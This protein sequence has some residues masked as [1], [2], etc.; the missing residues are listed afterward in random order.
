MSQL[1]TRIDQNKPLRF[2]PLA[3]E[4]LE[5][6]VHNIS[7]VYL[8]EGDD[9]RTVR[10][11]TTEPCKGGFL[12]PLCPMQ[13]PLINMIPQKMRYDARGNE[14]HFPRSR[15]YGVLGY[16]HNAGEPRILVAS[17]T[18][19]RGM[20]DLLEEHEDITNYTFKIKFE[21]PAYSS[22]ALARADDDIQLD[23]VDLTQ[24]TDRMRQQF[25]KDYRTPRSSSDLAMAIDPTTTKS[26]RG[27]MTPPPPREAEPVATQPP[28]RKAEAP[29]PTEP[30]E[31][32]EKSTEGV[33]VEGIKR[34]IIMLATQNSDKFTQM[35]EALQELGLDGLNDIPDDTAQ[36][37][38]AAV[39]RVVGE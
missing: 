11:Y 27:D 31:T 38:L 21:K 7:A 4:I 28:K 36:D 10:R 3:N 33:D 15:K 8:G 34:E 30:Q 9:R 2:S 1:Y 39:K 32:P 18:A 6:N 12:C 23:G 14:Q 20:Q 5:V 22:T 13:D 17:K 26:D 19:V 35:T 37:A 24:L 25:D 29:A 16:D